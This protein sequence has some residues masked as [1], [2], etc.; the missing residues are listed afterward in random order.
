MPG[1]LSSV[2]LAACT[3]AVFCF[4]ATGANA[5]WEVSD[6]ANIGN[7]TKQ[8]AAEAV[9]AGKRLEM[10]NN[11]ILELARLRQQFEA[12]SHGDLAAL[13]SLSPELGSLGLTSPLGT[14]MADV[15]NSISGLGGGLS[16][17]YT[18][19]QALRRN[20]QLYTPSGAD[21]RAVAINQA[22]VALASQK[23][24]A[25]LVLASNAERLTQLTALRQGLGSSPDVKAAMDATA[26]LVGEQATATA[27]G[28]QL[29]A[30][31]INQNAQTRTNVARE[32]QQVRCNIERLLSTAKRAQAVAESGVVQ[33][34]TASDPDFKCSIPPVA[35]PPAVA[36][37]V[38]Y[39]RTAPVTDGGRGGDSTT[40]SVMTSQS[41]GA[42]AAAN[43]EALGVSSSALAA[44]CVLESNCSANVG[45]AGT[46]SGAFQ[47]SD[48]TYAQTVGEVRASNPNL[49]SQIISKNDPASQ[50][51]AA[52][53]YLKDGAL[54]L[55]RADVSNP[56][57]LDVRGYYNFGPANGA[58][59]AR[60]PDNQLMSAT[61][62]G[63]SQSALTAN[64]I[65]SATTV[66][67][68]RAGVVSKIGAATASQ[69]VL[70][71]MKST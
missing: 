59:L 53:Q 62:S 71:G 36:S 10:I 66:G 49:A 69:S 34:N 22:A 43:A 70:I 25:Q 63:L 35:A 19:G 17:T 7:T 16:T 38:N 26:R 33:V 50:S 24:A 27:Q 2:A 46:I 23:A 45:G 14:D 51:I 44:T 18:L 55:Q 5:Q 65:G 54:A 40:L 8:V 20:D 9:A 1:R 47:M 57:V 48:G 42:A 31:T 64:G 56:S 39:E 28:N 3:A 52:A 60:A 12:L 15:A 37:Y 67:Q 21:F 32:Q 68:W 6:L 41:W 13:S 58:E 4:F 29:L 30:I 11:Q 61:L